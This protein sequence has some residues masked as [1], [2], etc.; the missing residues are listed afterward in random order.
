MKNNEVRD[1]LMA[2]YFYLPSLTGWQNSY[3]R[4]SNPLSCS[5]RFRTLKWVTQPK[6]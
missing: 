1:A 2:P 4:Y 6:L 5:I 3:V